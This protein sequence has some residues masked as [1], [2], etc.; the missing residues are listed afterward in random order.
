MY[1]LHFNFTTV[2]LASDSMTAPTLIFSLFF[3]LFTSGLVPDDTSL[4]RPSVAKQ[5]FSLA[6]GDSVVLAM[7]PHQRLKTVVLA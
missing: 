4:V 6:L 7:S 5:S 2:D 1:A 3:F